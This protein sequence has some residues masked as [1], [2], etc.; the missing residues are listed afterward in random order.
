MMGESTLSVRDIYKRIIAASIHDHGV[1]LSA[2]EVK[3]VVMD[4]AIRRAAGLED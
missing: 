3:A 4:D 1:R 2:E